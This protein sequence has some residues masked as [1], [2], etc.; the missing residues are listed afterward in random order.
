MHLAARKGCL[1]CV[2]CL[3]DHGADTNQQDRVNNVF[4]LQGGKTALIWAAANGYPECTRL[5]VEGGAD[6]NH[7]DRVAMVFN[8]RTVILPCILPHVEDIIFA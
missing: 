1:E 5:L 4:K 8:Y 6:V 7:Q 3:I 2:K